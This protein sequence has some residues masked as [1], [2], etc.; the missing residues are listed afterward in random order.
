MI[1][2]NENHVLS[3]I[4][5]HYDIEISNAY[6]EANGDCD[7]IDFSLLDKILNDRFNISHS[8]T[9][10]NFRFTSR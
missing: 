8:P 2:N 7:K 4:S 3:W 1:Q 9:D 5:E 6:F 10:K